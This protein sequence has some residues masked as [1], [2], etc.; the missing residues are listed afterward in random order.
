MLESMTLTDNP[1]MPPDAGGYASG[2]AVQRVGRGWRPGL[3]VRP[4]GTGRPKQVSSEFR[5]IT[6]EPTVQ[7]E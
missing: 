3:I 5:Q 2:I 7:S 1:D 6:R 4:V